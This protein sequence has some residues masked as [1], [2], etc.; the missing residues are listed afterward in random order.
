[1]TVIKAKKCPKC[2]GSGRSKSGA[3]CKKCQGTGEVVVSKSKNARKAVP[4]SPL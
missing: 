2:L 1:M 4:L 3:R